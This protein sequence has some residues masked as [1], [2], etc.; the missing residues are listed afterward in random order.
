MTAAGIRDWEAEVRRWV[1]DNLVVV[2][3]AF[4]WFMQTGE[5]PEVRALKRKY[6][7]DGQGRMP[8]CS[9]SRISQTTTTQR[10]HIDQNN[11]IYQQL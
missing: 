7:Q 6:F 2:Q 10:N 1:S 8:T 11:V 5:W 9:A 4:Q 3:G